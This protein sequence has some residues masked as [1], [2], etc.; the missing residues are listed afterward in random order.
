[1]NI[2]MSESNKLT[3]EDKKISFWGSFIRNWVSS[4]ALLGLTGALQTPGEPLRYFTQVFHEI[5]HNCL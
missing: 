3:K 5:L 4:E 2:L 1:M